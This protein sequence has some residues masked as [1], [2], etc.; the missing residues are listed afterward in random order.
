MI[1]YEDNNTIFV[2]EIAKVN[3]TNL[4]IKNDKGM[5]Y[6]YKSINRGNL[7]DEK[8]TYKIKKYKIYYPLC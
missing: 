2:E 4:S 7:T 8:K 6:N 5:V 3:K 1:V